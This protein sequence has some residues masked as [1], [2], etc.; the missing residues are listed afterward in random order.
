MS[1]EEYIEWKN[2][3]GKIF[4]KF[5]INVEYTFETKENEFEEYWKSGLTP[6]K[7]VLASVKKDHDFLLNQNKD[8]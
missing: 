5:K 7:A 2:E 8:E 6:V 4:Q 3:V 1:K